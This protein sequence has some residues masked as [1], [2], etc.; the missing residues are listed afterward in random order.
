MSMFNSESNNGSS[1][2]SDLA[3]HLAAADFE[4]RPLI[5]QYSFYGDSESSFSIEDAKYH[6]NYL[7]KCL[8][9]VH[10]KADLVEGTFSIAFQLAD[11]YEDQRAANQNNFFINREIDF[12]QKQIDDW[13]DKKARYEAMLEKAVE[14]SGNVTVRKREKQ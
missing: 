5:E 10:E 9:D 11:F 1:D 4:K 13:Y 6:I 2:L 12:L 7:S 8:M 3:V 14:N